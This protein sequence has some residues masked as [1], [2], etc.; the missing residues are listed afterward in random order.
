[1]KKLVAKILFFFFQRATYHEVD[2]DPANAAKLGGLSKFGRKVIQEMNRL[3]MMVDLS[4]TSYRT[5]LDALDESKAPVIF[6]HSSVTAV[7]NITRNTRDDVLVKLVNSLKKI[8]A[9]ELASTLFIYVYRK[10]IVV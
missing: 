7:C 2:K 10:R 8:L 9:I 3:G 1:L 5:Q 6:S 4:H